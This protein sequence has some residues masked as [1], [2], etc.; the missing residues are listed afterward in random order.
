VD[1]VRRHPKRVLLGAI[2]I[3]AGTAVLIAAH[4]GYSEVADRFESIDPSWLAAVA[5]GQLAAFTGYALAYR[6]IGTV[7]GGPRID[8]ALLVRL[9]ATGFGA[10]ALGGG[11]ALDYRALRSLEGDERAAAVRVLALGALEYVVIAPAACVAAAVMLIEGSTVLGSVLWPWALAV[12]AGFAIGFWLAAR[13]DRIPEGKAGKGWRRLAD[14]LAGIN[15]IG[16]MA[17]EPLRFTPALLGIGLYWGGE[18]VSLW[19]SI[20]AFGDTLGPGPLIIGLG[21]GYVLTRRSMPLA[22]AGITELL[23]TLALV[24]VGLDL[25]TALAATIVYRLFSFVLPMF[26]ALWARQEVAHLIDASGATGTSPRA[27]GGAI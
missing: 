1:S 19:A 26:P 24:W 22:G 23:L 13:P 3:A 20:R 5:A 15:L 6:R 11:L 2:A 25:A 27:R 10:F 16:R 14:A 21:T 18:V 9:V 4:A 17:S 7:L 12:P 8:A